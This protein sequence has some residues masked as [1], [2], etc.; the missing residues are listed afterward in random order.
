MRREARTITLARG[1]RSCWACAAGG[2]WEPVQRLWGRR[3]KVSEKLAGSC[4]RRARAR[5]IP[6]RALVLQQ[7]TRSYVAWWLGVSF[8]GACCCPRGGSCCFCF[9]VVALAP[10]VC[11][12]RV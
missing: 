7:S 5:K 10:W 3:Y 2:R 6:P 9:S 1:Y 8:R 12:W 11:G 4:A